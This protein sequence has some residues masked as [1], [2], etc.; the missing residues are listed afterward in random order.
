MILLVY[1]T[2]RW[3]IWGNILYTQEGYPMDTHQTLRICS[4]NIPDTQST[5][6]WGMSLRKMDVPRNIPLYFVL[7]KWNYYKCRMD[8][9]QVRDHNEGSLQ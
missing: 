2:K 4:E 6:F 1:E 3:Y 5:I 7:M 8:I 9:P